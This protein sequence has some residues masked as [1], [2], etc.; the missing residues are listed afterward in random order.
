MTQV[1][2]QEALRAALLAQE[3]EIQV[4]ANFDVTAQQ[5]VTYPLLLHS[6]PARWTPLFQ[7]FPSSPTGR[8]PMAAGCSSATLAVSGWA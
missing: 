6:A 2:T 1:S 8:Q 5:N 7:T 4:I 3:P